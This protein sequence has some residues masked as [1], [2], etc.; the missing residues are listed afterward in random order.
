MVHQVEGDALLPPIV[1]IKQ[2]LW[3]VQDGS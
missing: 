3:A 1:L 2:V